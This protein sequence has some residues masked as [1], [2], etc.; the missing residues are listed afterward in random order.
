MT[1]STLQSP[2]DNP[3][4]DNHEQVHRFVL[5]ESKD[6]VAYIAVHN[7][8]LGPALGGCRIK[9]YASEADALYDVLRLSRGM[10]Y[11]NAMAGLPLGGGKAV[12]IA[13][14]QTEKTPELMQ[15]FGECVQS[16]NGA[17]VTA[18]DSGTTEEDMENILKSTSFVT[19]LRPALLKEKGFD[20]LGGNP[21]PLTALGCFEGIKAAVL[22]RYD[23]TD[24]KGLKASIQGVGAVGLSLAE[25]LYSAGVELTIADINELNIKKATNVLKGVSVV[26]A[27]EIYAVNAEIFVPCALGGV[28]N[29]DT[30]PQLT[31]EIIA[32]PANN[33]LAKSKHGEMLAA[34]NITYVPDYVINSGGVICV[35]YEYF[36]TSGHNPYELTLTEYAM[37]QHVCGIGNAVSEILSY[38]KTNHINPGKA[39]DALAEEKF[40]SGTNSKSQSSAA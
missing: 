30:I 3:A 13:D 14:P 9:K 22:H 31:S 40:G 23:R 38:A 8:A 29:E 20:T 19:G 28:L 26:R 17:Y 10:T 25:L 12:I 16:L 34:Q 35:G 37:T 11:K 2:T 15:K 7:T 24:L 36:M 32:G 6:I 1:Q 33:Q 39:A 4:F 18:E 21:S 27:D 5:D